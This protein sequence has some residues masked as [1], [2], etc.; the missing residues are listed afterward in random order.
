MEV[1]AERPFYAQKQKYPDV[2]VRYSEFTQGI[3]RSTSS[4][5]YK[6]NPPNSPPRRNSTS[7][8]LQDKG[9]GLRPKG[10]KKTQKRR[11]K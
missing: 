11:T 7:K 9:V 3:R 4:S 1:E 5:S 10:K 2:K 6:D 8:S